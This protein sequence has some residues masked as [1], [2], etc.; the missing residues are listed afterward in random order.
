MRSLF[1]GRFQRHPGFEL[2]DLATESIV[3][4]MT[5]VFDESLDYFFVFNANLLW[6]SFR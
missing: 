1:Q 5:G 2:M 4:L 3:F 6:I